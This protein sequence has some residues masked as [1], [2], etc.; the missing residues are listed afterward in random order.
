MTE[1]GG[2]GKIGRAAAGLALAAL[3]AAGCSGSL[4]ELPSAPSLDAPAPASE[5]DK[6]KAGQTAVDI[7][8]LSKAGPLGDQAL[9][10]AAAPVTIVQYMSLTCPNCASFQAA[11]LPKLKKA[12]IDTGKVRFVVREYPIGHSAAAAAIVSRCVPA[13]DYFKAVDKLLL[14]Q[15]DWTAQEVKKDEI[16]DAV[17]FTG[18]K[19]ERF[20]SCLAANDINDALFEVKSR[21]KALGVIGTPTFFVNG[22]KLTGAASFEDVQA[23]IEGALAAQ[24][25]IMQES[26]PA[27]S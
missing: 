24:A 18:L 13:K 16:Y 3:A 22:R 9:G 19:R 10:K 21:G 23:A 17:K 11:V 27:R 15:R 8:E 25:P 26:R 4:P 14:H 5:A 2:R 1:A 7:A 12:Y 6:P 20:E